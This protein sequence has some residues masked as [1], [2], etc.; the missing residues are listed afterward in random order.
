MSIVNFAPY[1]ESDGSYDTDIDEEILLDLEEDI[2]VA[3]TISCTSSM[4]LFHSY[5]LDEGVKLL[6]TTTLA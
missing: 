6:S 3:F 4:E 1:V 2:L 5:E